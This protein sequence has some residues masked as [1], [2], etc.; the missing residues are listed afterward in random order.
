MHTCP[1]IFF[2]S[3]SKI[4]ILAY[5][6]DLKR[7][8]RSPRSVIVDH[9]RSFLVL[10]TTNQKVR[11]VPILRPI[12]RE[13]TVKR[14]VANRRSKKST[15]TRKSG[16]KSTYSCGSQDGKAGAPVD[17]SSLCR[18]SKELSQGDITGRNCSLTELA[19]IAVAID[20]SRK[21]Y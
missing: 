18:S 4:F 5:Y 21:T 3:F 10:V 14:N 15:D 9:C 8:F 20:E 16:R 6:R 7:I 11:T 1:L 19:S 2:L 12:K 17:G 13:S